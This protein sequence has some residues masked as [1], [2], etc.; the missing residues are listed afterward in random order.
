MKKNTF[1]NTMLMALWACAGLS[2][3]AAEGQPARD[4]GTTVYMNGHVYTGKGWADAFAESGGVITAVGSNAEVR[5]LGGGHP[6]L[7][8]LQGKTV[9][10]GFADLHVHPGYAGKFL[11]PCDVAADASAEKIADAVAR[12]AGRLKPGEWI[13][14]AGWARDNPDVKKFDRAILDKAA[15]DNPV[16]LADASGHD[17]WANSLALAAAGFTRDSPDLPGGTIERDALREPTGL[18]REAPA[19][20]LRY[21]M[22]P[23]SDQEA[24]RLVKAALD[25]LSA[26]GV[27]AI[28]DAGIRKHD[29]KAYAALSDSGQ[30][31]QRVRGCILW[32]KESPDF[33]EI[34]ANRAQY[35]RPNFVLDCVKVFMDGT[36]NESHSAAMLHPYERHDPKQPATAGALEVKPD[37]LKAKVS[38]WDKEGLIVK[39]HCGGDKA[40]QTALDAIEAARRANGAQGPRHELAHV[41]FIT[42][43]DLK[44]ARRLGVALEFSP[45]FWYP[46]PVSDGIVR[47][48]GPVRSAHLWPVKRAINSG[49]LV[50]AA[51]DW[52]GA[53][54]PNPWLVIETLVTRKAPGNAGAA[55]GRAEAVTLK[56]A[57]DIYTRN[58]AAVTPETTDTGYLSVGARAD[59]IV[60]DQD[61]FAIPIGDVHKIKVQRTVIDGKTV[62]GN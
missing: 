57:I 27:T 39:F 43:S 61:P 33:D 44:R 36:P 40:V 59:F 41:V 8:D 20:K 1:A 16:V 13:Y 62:Y 22:P 6:K 54:D 48:T 9:F 35:Q 34:H 58:A 55:L 30:L 12:C 24:A 50:L 29:A 45:V 5:A 10:P 11:N 3:S 53:N 31:Q 56:Q 38:A 49:N 25:V 21:T 7:V 52:P 47:A 23:G 4:T 46:N 60:I 17:V 42:A 26:K 15:P 2:A 18:L 14:G 37:V 51:S 28:V 19:A 32:N